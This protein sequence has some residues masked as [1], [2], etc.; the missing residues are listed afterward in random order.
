MPDPTLD[1][2]K[3]GTSPN[4]FVSTLAEFVAAETKRTSAAGFARAIHA[5]FEKM[6][7]DK[8][9]F[10]LFWKLR[11]MEPEEAELMLSS[12]LRYCRWAQLPIGAQASLFVGSDDSGSPS[13]KAV[14]DLDM[15]AIYEQGHAAGLAGRSSTDHSFMPGTPNHEQFF[16][17]WQDGQA[18]LAQR[19]FTD[20][21]DDGTPLKPEKKG[22]GPGKAKAGVERRT[23]PKPGS[24]SRG[25]GGSAAA[26][27]AMD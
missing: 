5:R 19:L 8:K 4:D 12:A 18:A 21:P 2:P 7:V 13:D 27:R 16:K 1:M 24:R 17:G 26:R 15:A 6:G 22:R 20:L 11:N 14:G 3:G 10:A 23:A 9:G 25:R